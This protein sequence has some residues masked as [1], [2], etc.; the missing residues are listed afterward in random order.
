MRGKIIKVF[1]NPNRED[2]RRILDYLH[3]SGVSNSR[4]IKSAMLDFLD[5]QDGGRENGLLLQEVKETIRESFQGLQLNGNLTVPVS[6]SDEEQVSPFDF[7]DALES[8]TA[9][10]ESSPTFSD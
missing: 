6:E 9:F 1:L 10:D 8:G 5:R 4:A 3:Y 7:L 2:E